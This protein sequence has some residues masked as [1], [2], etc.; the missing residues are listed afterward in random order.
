[1]AAKRGR[2]ITSWGQAFT[3]LSVEGT[4][5]PGQPTR[6][7]TWGIPTGPGWFD[8]P[9]KWNVLLPPLIMGA[10]EIMRRILGQMKA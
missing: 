3:P 1:M 7:R 6:L 8:R 9:G 2:N 10:L 5:G 4:P